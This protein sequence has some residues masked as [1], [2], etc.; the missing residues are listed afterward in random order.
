MRQ[1]MVNGYPQPYWRSPAH[2]G[3]YG[4]GSNS[5]DDLAGLAFASGIGAELIDDVAGGLLDLLVDAVN[6]L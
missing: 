1:V 6:P 2:V 4:N 3:Y 5:L